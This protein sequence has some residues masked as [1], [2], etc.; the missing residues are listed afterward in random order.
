MVKKL[1][2]LWCQEVVLYIIH[3]KSLPLL[4]S[5]RLVNF[6]KVLS[7][8]LKSKLCTFTNTLTRTRCH[9]SRCLKILIRLNRLYKLSKIFKLIHKSQHHLNRSKQP[10][11][12][13]QTLLSY[14]NGLHNRPTKQRQILTHHPAWTNENIYFIFI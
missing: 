5:S 8:Q 14:L 13:S 2:N 3:R 6:I 1:S 11:L 7:Y 4:Y 10:S 12:V 9:S